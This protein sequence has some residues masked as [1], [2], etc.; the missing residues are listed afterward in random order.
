MVILLILMDPRVNIVT[1]QQKSV[2][3]PPMLLACTICMVMSGNGV[4]MLSIKVTTTHLMMVAP[5][6]EIPIVVLRCCAVVRG[7]PKPLTAAV[8]SATRSSLAATSTTLVF[9]WCTILPRNFLPVGLVR[10]ERARVGSLLPLI[11]L[12]T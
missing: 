8:P 7:V 5:G 9:G 6:L 10:L 3:S 11:S 2:L 12:P 1:E 4:K